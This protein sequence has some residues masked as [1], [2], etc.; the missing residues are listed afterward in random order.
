MPDVAEIYREY[1]FKRAAFQSYS[2]AAGR[3]LR[4]EL[5]EMAGPAGAYGIF[6]FKRGGDCES[7]DVGD[8][9]CLSSQLLHV[10]KDRFLIAVVGID[11]DPVSGEELLILARATSDT[12]TGTGTKPDIVMLLPPDGLEE[13]S[14]HYLMGSRALPSAYNL[15]FLDTFRVMEGVGGRIGENTVFLFRYSSEDEAQ[16]MLPNVIARLSGPDLY[17]LLVLGNKDYESTESTRPKFVLATE[18]SYI[19]MAVGDDI[20]SL[21]AVLDLLRGRVKPAPE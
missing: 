7:I 14:I 18:A 10:W 3:T 4:L 21:S 12:I 19:L 5:Y 1:G 6:T 20:S 17:R 11:S 13:T 16:R 8:E 15:G 2:D 9:A